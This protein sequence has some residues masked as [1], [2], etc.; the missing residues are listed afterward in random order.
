MWLPLP[1]GSNFSSSK[2]WCPFQRDTKGRRTGNASAFPPPF[3]FSLGCLEV[4]APS[5]SFDE[6]KLQARFR[7]RDVVLKLRISSS[8]KSLFRGIHETGPVARWTP[9]EAGLQPSTLGLWGTVVW[10]GCGYCK[11]ARNKLPAVRVGACVLSSLFGSSSNKR[12]DTQTS[13]C[14]QKSSLL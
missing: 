1:V 10:L 2:S 14:T 11:A 4:L 8:Q 13:T 7:H 3:E 6:V 9:T 5:N 12:L